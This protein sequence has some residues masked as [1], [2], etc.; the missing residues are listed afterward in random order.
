MK[1]LMALCAV[2]AALGAVA[3]G[4]GSSSSDSSTAEGSSSGTESTDQSSG[5]SS[6]VEEAESNFASIVEFP[7]KIQIPPMAKSPPTGVK[8]T[9]V[10]CP[11]PIC[12]TQ[13]EGAKEAAKVLGWQLKPVNQGLTPNTIQSAWNAVA[14]DPGDGVIGLSILPN[15]A[16]TSQ[17][18]QVAAAGVPYVGV[19]QGDPPGELMA[20]SI[21]NPPQEA[22]EGEALADWVVSD[23]EGEASEVIFVF[24]PT[25]LSLYAGV[26]SF[27]KRMKELS[28]DST[29]VDLKVSIAN[30]ATKVP[31][32]MVNAIRS[33]PGA[34][35]VVSDFGDLMTGVPQ[36]IKA[37]NLT[38]DPKVITR[39]VS[40][41]NLEDIQ[42]G[43][44]AGG[45]TA[46]LIE[47][48][49]KGVDLIAR[50]LNEEK[51]YSKNP[52]SAVTFL[53]EEN[54][55]EDISVPY[56]IPGFRDSYEEA[57]GK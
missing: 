18:E 46:E 51:L 1:K 10:T 49:W 8:L 5:G 17:L 7:P 48:G 13:E 41:A 14:Q 25:L 37:A 52:P 42:N 6:A 39:A 21:A 11:L 43:G 20:A 28:P 23:S 35:Y 32:E 45:M 31:E 44:M 57:W 22:R 53:T 9:M 47:L 24:D 50:L 38:S 55:P 54:L 4:C 12:T 40:T 3:A 29:I 27:H 26:E 30:V 19:A 36:A 56:E 34:K 2:L 15:S 16:I 33:H